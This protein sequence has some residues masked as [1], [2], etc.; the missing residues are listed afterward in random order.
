M[1]VKYLIIK[2]LSLASAVR[3]KR[4]NYLLQLQTIGNKYVDLGCTG[5]KSVI[6]GYVSKQNS[7]NIVKQMNKHNGIVQWYLPGSSFLVLFI[8]FSTL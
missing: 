2:K 1:Y 4:C 7:M 6:I 5:C 8:Y 3:W